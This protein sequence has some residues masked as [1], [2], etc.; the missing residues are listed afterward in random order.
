[1][2]GWMTEDF[3]GLGLDSPRLDAELLLAHAL[4][5]DRVRLYMDLDRPLERAEL[6][7]LRAL[8]R[9]RSQHEPVAYLVGF[10]EFYGRRFEVSPDVLIPRPDTETLVEHALRLL[11]SQ[12]EDKLLDLCTGSGAVAITLLAERPELHAD[13]TDLSVRA[14]SVARR[15]AEAL[16]VSERLG[17]LQ[18]DLFG[19]LEPG[20]AYGMITVNPPYI[21]E[22]EWRELERGVRE[23]EPRVALVA[24]EGGLEVFERIAAD[25]PERLLPGGWLLMEVGH[26]QAV[27]VAALLR[28]QQAFGEP[29][30][31]RD[32]S[33]I[34]RVVAARRH[35]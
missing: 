2:L 11:P 25:A 21:A 7:M 3:G 18:G 27:D 9:R 28:K 19:A 24:G 22:G 4:A 35:G 29:E 30:I 5:C 10:K 17:L 33:G 6:E 20:A 32:L 23:H 31:H 14:L 8:V 1:M 12:E 15:N 13:A 26:T 34:E 16:G